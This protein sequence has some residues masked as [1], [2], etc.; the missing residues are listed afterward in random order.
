MRKCWLRLLLILTSLV[1]LEVGLRLTGFGRVALYEQSDIYEYA[2]IP[3][4]K[5]SRFGKNY[6]I[7][8]EGMRAGPLEKGEWRILK[9]GDSV[10]NGGAYTDQSDLASELLN[11]ELKSILSNARVVQVSAGSWGPDN[12]FSWMNAHGDF[13]AKIIVLVFSSHDWQD[14]MNFQKVVGQLAFYPNK[15]PSLAIIDVCSWLWSRYGEKVDWKAIAQTAKRSQFNDHNIGWD[16]FIQYCKQG[17][18]PLLVYH[19]A[20]A[21]ELELNTW[22]S[23][24]LALEEFLKN[25]ET[26]TISGLNANLT[27]DDYH[28]GIHLNPNGQRKLA[29]ILKM[30]L[31][32]LLQE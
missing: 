7:N 29:D 15:E 20:N 3:N 5:L 24:G 32:P 26:P 8:S 14:Q 4:Q 19:H 16:Q 11:V 30:H 31:V 2:L 1:L 9:F 25:S 22:N 21:Q 10:L 12:A 17:Q 23:D 6:E 13:D 18:I 28:D 27:K